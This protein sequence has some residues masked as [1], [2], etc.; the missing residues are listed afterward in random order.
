MARAPNELAS[1]PA[2]C[3]TAGHL[4]SQGKEQRKAA[5]ADDDFEAAFRKFDKDS[6]EERE[7]DVKRDGG[8]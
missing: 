6:E 2:R 1:V 5:V 8:T 4:W 3:V 7:G